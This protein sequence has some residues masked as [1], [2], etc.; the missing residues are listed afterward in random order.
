MKKSLALPDIKIYDKRIISKCDHDGVKW[1]IAKK[2]SIGN[3]QIEIP[4]W[5]IDIW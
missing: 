5:N 3:S 2:K 1:N 4:M